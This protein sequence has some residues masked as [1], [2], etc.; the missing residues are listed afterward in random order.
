MDAH[1]KIYEITAEALERYQN[2]F[3]SGPTTEVISPGRMN[4]RTIPE[5]R[6]PAMIDPAA[7]NN[8][9]LPL[10]NSAS[11]VV[12]FPFSTKSGMFHSINKKIIAY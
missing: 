4:G 3:G 2:T 5:R 9:L 6:S 7:S 1:K 10:S 8:G 11:R 12:I